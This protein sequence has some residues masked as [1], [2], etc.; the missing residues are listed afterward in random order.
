LKPSSSLNFDS[1][2]RIMRRIVPT[3]PSASI[4]ED[5]VLMQLIQPL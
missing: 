2:E 3:S 1:V 4:T 5:N